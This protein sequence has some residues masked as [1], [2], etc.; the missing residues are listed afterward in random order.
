MF[1]FSFLLGNL[2][3]LCT[4]LFPVAPEAIQAIG[5]RFLMAL[6]EI[7]Y[8]LRRNN[9]APLLVSFTFVNICISILSFILIV[10]FCHK[11]SKYLGQKY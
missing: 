4:T 9:C 3:Y 1:Q 6:P 10:I 8:S 2:F 5:F 7:Q 11:F